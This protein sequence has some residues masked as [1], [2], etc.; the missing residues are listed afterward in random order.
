MDYAKLL[1][2]ASKGLEGDGENSGSGRTRLRMGVYQ[3]CDRTLDIERRFDRA[4]LAADRIRHDFSTSIAFYDKNLHD[5]QIYSERLLEDFPR[6]VREKE[7]KVYYQPKFDIIRTD[8]PL[9][10]SAEALVRWIHPELGFI[11]PGVFIPLLEENGLIQQLDYY[12]WEE[13]ARQMK[14]WRQRYDMTVPVSVNISRIDMYDPDLMKKLEELVDRYEIKPEAF[15][16]EITESAYTE[17]SEQIIETVNK[18]RSMGFKIEMDDF[19]TGYSSLNMIST[20]PIDVLKIDMLFIRSAFSMQKDV[21]MLELIIDIAD[22][23]SVPVI[24]EGV[25]T[26]EQVDALKALGCEYVQG[27]YF[28]KPLPAEEFD[29]FIEEKKKYSGNGIEEDFLKLA[30]K[31]RDARA[32]EAEFLSIVKA[33]ASEYFSIYYVNIDTDAYNKYSMSEEYRKLEIEHNGKDFFEDTKNNIERVIYEEDKEKAHQVW[34]KEYILNELEKSDRYTTSYRI[35]MDGEPVYIRFNVMKM[36]DG[37]NR[38][39]VV[40]IS[41]VDAQM[42]KE[43][44]YLKARELARKDALTGL[45]NKLAYTQ[46][47]QQF[48]ERIA[49][50]ETMP[51]AIAVCDLND[52]KG[53]NDTFGHA[54]GDK[55]IID[56]CQRI[57]SIFKHSPVFRV[58]G[59]EFVAI[60]TGKDFENREALL[61][62]M[63]EANEAELASAPTVPVII[64]CG[65]AE[66]LY[67]QDHILSEV[68]DRA[69]E[70][71]Y[72]DK[73]QIKES[74]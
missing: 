11:N 30:R 32:R 39:I 47:E 72:L 51:L 7:L 60:L 56:A 26:K 63:H 10:S 25:E 27:F 22:Y 49:S 73:K 20:L 21:R 57:C 1:Q 2:H 59:D 66:F 18:L 14:E 64:A 38:H 6:A 48:D 24:A 5:A 74:F 28:S 15:A 35:M 33:L 45:K 8:K 3:N 31:D 68:F 17:D 43:Q 29:P 4:K 40:G 58:G 16:L 50:G 65:I 41:N 19:G 23:I 37:N 9:L 52:L 34:D 36:E 67:G 12:V 55:Y 71:M 44:E 42:K 62:R 61:Q 53:V 54:A 13:S 69:D 70:K 46:A